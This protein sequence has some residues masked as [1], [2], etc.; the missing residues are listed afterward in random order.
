MAGAAAAGIGNSHSR[1]GGSGVRGCGA[2]ASGAAG[3]RR[4]AAGVSTEPPGAD[5]RDCACVRV[6]MRARSSMCVLCAADALR[7]VSARAPRLCGDANWLL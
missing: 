7:V 5:G 3:G 6:C 2:A 4:A 1:I